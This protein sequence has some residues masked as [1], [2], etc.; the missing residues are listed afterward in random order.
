MRNASWTRLIY[1]SS[2]SIPAHIPA[3]PVENMS[4]FRG[5][6]VGNSSEIQRNYRSQ[7][8]LVVSRY[9]FA[10]RFGG[11][12]VD[13]FPR[14]SAKMLKKHGINDWA[15]LSLLYNPHAPQVPGAPGLFY[16]I[17]DTHAEAPWTKRIFVRLDDDKWLYVG[18]YAFTPVA[19]LTVAEYKLSSPKVRC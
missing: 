13:T 16:V 19:S 11:S 14:P 9:F 17:G 2:S 5:K 18:Q 7:W 1:S 15:F 10:Q 6:L 12:F 8:K 3:H 4:L